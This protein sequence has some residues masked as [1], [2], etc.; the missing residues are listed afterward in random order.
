M[1][2][3]STEPDGPDQAGSFRAADVGTAVICDT[4]QQAQRVGALMHGDAKV[5]LAAVN[6]EEYASACGLA[7]IAYLRGATLATIRTKDETFDIARIMVLGV[8]TET[9][10]QTVAPSFYF[11]VIKI[12]ERVA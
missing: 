12:D 1:G 10:L 5:A 11:M 9:G 2:G 4:E 3:M 8:P 6:A 7:N